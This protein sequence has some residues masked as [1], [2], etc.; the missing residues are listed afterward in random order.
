MYPP[1]YYTQSSQSMCS[2]M[3]EIT[4]RL[5]AVGYFLCLWLSLAE[6]RTWVRHLLNFREI[7]LWNKQWGRGCLTS[8]W[9]WSWNLKRKFPTHCKVLETHAWERYQNHCFR[10]DELCTCL[11]LFTDCVPAK[12]RRLGKTERERRVKEKSSPYIQVLLFSSPRHRRSK[13]IP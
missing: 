9:K 5:S 10:V 12:S 2:K 1:I 13:V 6:A 11:N 4:N 3:C 8:H 7:L